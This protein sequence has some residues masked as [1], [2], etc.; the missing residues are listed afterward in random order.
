MSAIIDKVRK[1]LRLAESPNANEAALAA[2]K[3]QRLID[4]HNLSAQLL[5]LDAAEAVPDEPICDFED[6]GAPLET[7]RRH[8]RW[9]TQLAGTIARANGCRVYINGENIALVGRP[10]DAETVRYL[11]AYLTREVERLCEREGAGCGVT[12][13]NNFRLGV[14]YAIMEK[15]K[16]ARERFKGEARKQATS[17]MALMR[18]NSALARVEERGMDV[19]DWIKTNLKLVSRGGSGGSYDP[20]AVAAG[21]QAGKSIRIGGAKAGL[22]RGS[23][24]ALNA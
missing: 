22:G 21:K 4:E 14:V 7:N 23:R 24:G 13:R 20:G 12:W 10:S 11:F 15:L 17:D 8:P 1:L 19:A 18:V 2:A 16:E 5:A 6:K 9:R 3:A